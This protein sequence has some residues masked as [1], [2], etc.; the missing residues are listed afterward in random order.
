MKSPDERELLREALVW[1][2]SFIRCNH[3]NAYADYPDMRNAIS[4][5]DGHTMDS[6]FHRT[7]IRAEVAEER[8]AEAHKALLA[9]KAFGSQ[10][11]THEGISVSYLIDQAIAED[12]P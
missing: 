5:A 8:L 6:E 4:L 2:V 1:A 10:G 12:T 11:E 7:L 3:P 9:A